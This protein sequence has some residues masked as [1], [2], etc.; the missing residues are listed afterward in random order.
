MLR[1]YQITVGVASLRRARGGFARRRLLVGL[2]VL[3]MLTVGGPTALGSSRDSKPELRPLWNAFPLNPAGARLDK[4]RSPRGTRGAFRPPAAQVAQGISSKA[5]HTSREMPSSGLDIVTIALLTGGGLVMLALLGLA[6][7]QLR[8]V[9]GYRLAPAGRSPSGRHDRRRTA[10]RGTS[11]V[12]ITGA[13][14]FR[15]Q[16]LVR[17][18]RRVARRTR[19]VVWTEDTRPVFVAC[20]LSVVLA[21][22]IVHVIV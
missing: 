20:A 7:T 9:F 10:W 12:V 11:G 1:R 3:A 19:K 15:K 4:P 13:F 22:V 6:G 17:R 18:I 5:A 14:G 21:F 8:D 16:P 2:A